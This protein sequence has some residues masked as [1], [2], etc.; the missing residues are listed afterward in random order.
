MY[1]TRLHVPSLTV[2]PSPRV[3]SPGSGISFILLPSPEHPRHGPKKVTDTGWKKKRK[4]EA[5]KVPPNRKNRQQKKITKCCR[6]FPFAPWEETCLTRLGAPGSSCRRDG[7]ALEQARRGTKQQLLPTQDLQDPAWNSLLQ[8]H[9]RYMHDRGCAIPFPRGRCLQE[10]STVP[11]PGHG[12]GG[13]V[14]AE[15][16]ALVPFWCSTCEALVR[17]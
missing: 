1:A 9:A 16:E 2:M 12:G 7:R 6:Y 13:L 15:E 8:V 14:Q 3:S 5:K 4:D 11:V 10:T 17:E